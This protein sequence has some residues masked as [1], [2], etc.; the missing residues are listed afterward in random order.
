MAVSYVSLTDGGVEERWHLNEG[1]YR[2]YENGSLTVQRAFNVDDQDWQTVINQLDALDSGNVLAKLRT[3]LTT[4][5]TYLNKV[6]AGTATAGDHT[7]QVAALSRQMVAVM[8]RSVLFT[9]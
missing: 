4:N 9:R 6:N 8:M 1:I 2:R 5:R 7:A 3:A